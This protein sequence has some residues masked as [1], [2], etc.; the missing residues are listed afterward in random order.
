MRAVSFEAQTVFGPSRLLGLCLLAP[1]YALALSDKFVRPQL[2]WEQ[3]KVEHIGVF[4]TLAV[5][6][7][8]RTRMRELVVLG[9]TLLVFAVG[10]EFGQ[11]LF[12][13]TRTCSF[14]D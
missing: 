1:V 10:I 11:A 6:L 12:T 9:L 5:L 7:G 14:I 13:L 8:W 3:D 2:F 4:F